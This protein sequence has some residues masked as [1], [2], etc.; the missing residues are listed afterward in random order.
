MDNNI[1]YL[2]VSLGEAIDKLT[3]LNIKYDKIQDKRRE[4]VKIEYDMLYNCNLSCSELFID[5]R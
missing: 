4:E 3:I 1:L 2:P 5:E